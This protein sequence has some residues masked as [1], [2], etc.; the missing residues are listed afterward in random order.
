MSYLS[1]CPSCG[2]LGLTSA[3]CPPGEKDSGDTA[4][5]AAPVETGMVALYGVP[6]TE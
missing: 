4:D 5:T 1:T 3:G 6:A 2:C